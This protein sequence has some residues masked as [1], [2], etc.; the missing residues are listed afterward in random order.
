MESKKMV[1][2]NLFAGQQWRCRHR[3]QIY[4][5]SGWEG[6]DGMKGESSIGTYT[7]THI[8]CIVGICGITQGTHTGAL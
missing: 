1:L 6:E 7:L 5:W 4:H 8:K 3:E 2:M